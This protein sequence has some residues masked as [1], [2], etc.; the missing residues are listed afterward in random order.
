MSTFTVSHNYEGMEIDIEWGGDD[1]DLNMQGVVS[2]HVEAYG[3]FLQL[4]PSHPLVD[5]I[6]LHNEEDMLRDAEGVYDEVRPRM[7][8]S[9]NGY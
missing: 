9:S 2:A 6:I 1:D 8:R 3:T 7:F 4:P 5:L